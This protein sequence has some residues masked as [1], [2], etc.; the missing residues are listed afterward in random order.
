MSSHDGLK[1]NSSQVITQ[2]RIWLRVEHRWCNLDVDLTSRSNL[3]HM[4]PYHDLSPTFYWHMHIVPILK[5]AFKMILILYMLVWHGCPMIA[6]EKGF[7][8]TSLLYYKQKRQ[9]SMMPSFP[10]ESTQKMLSYD[11]YHIM[12]KKGNATWCH[13]SHVKV[14]K[15]DFW[16]PPYYIITKKGNGTWHHHS[17]VKVLKK[18]FLM[19]SLSYYYQKRQWSMMPSLPCESTQKMLSNDPHIIYYQKGN[20]LTCTFPSQQALLPKKCPL[21]SRHSGQIP[22]ETFSDYTGS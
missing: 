17:H 3:C 19:T 8:M 12:T 2:D 15:N 10:C 22:L 5:I 14:L 9:W 16:W 6:L 20:V 18:C 1:Q 13:H 21:D 4:M 7:L 11:P